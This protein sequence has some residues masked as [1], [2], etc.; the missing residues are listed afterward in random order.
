MFFRILAG[1]VS[2]FLFFGLYMIIS[3]SNLHGLGRVIGGMV[4]FAFLFAFYAIKGNTEI[5]KQSRTTPSFDQ[6]LPAAQVWFSLILVIS[7]IGFIGFWLIFKST[8]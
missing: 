5:R 4:V 1:L 3:K 7:L 2:I 8:H 6:N